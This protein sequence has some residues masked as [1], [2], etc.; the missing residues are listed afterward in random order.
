MLLDF[1]SVTSKMRADL[2]GIG[3]DPERFDH[4]HFEKRAN[5]AKASAFLTGRLGADLPARS[6]LEQYRPSPEWFLRP[7]AITGLHGIN[8]M[9]RVLVLQEV[10]AR[11]LLQDGHTFDQEA[12]RWAAVTHDTR[13]ADDWDDAPHGRRAAA[14]VC[15][16]LQKLIPATSLET[17]AYLNRWHV[18]SDDH[19]PAMTP[20]L[21]VFKDADSIDR[22]RMGGWNLDARKLRSVYARR[23][24]PYL[25]NAL[26]LAS[27]QHRRAGASLFDCVLQAAVDL[28]LVADA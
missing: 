24:V 8:H 19:A 21:A 27:G 4:Y 18:P 15:E 28:G 11:L 9:A 17:V 23:Y 20:E 13:R 12:M 3:D 10:M 5:L 7:K 6:L 26:I 2:S 25:A 14:W 16:H 1:L 22:I